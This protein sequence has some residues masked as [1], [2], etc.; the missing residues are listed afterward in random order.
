MHLLFNRNIDMAIIHPRFFKAAL[1]SN[2]LPT[3]QTIV[4]NFWPKNMVTRDIKQN[5]L[6]Y[7]HFFWEMFY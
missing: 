3:H 2:I 4:S 5:I 6:N 7:C 1:I